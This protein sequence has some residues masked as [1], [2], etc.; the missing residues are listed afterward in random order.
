MRS[1]LV[2]A[3]ALM[4]SSISYSQG[5]HLTTKKCKNA[6][7]DRVRKDCIIR[8]IQ[9]FVD[10]NYDITAISS[11]AKP[12]SNRVYTRFKIDKTGKIVDIQTKSTAFPLEVEA[13]RVLESFPNLILSKS[14][15][16]ENAIIEEEVFTLPII[17]NVNK[18]EININLNKG[19]RLTGNQ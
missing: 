17:F 13:V 19:E 7:N 4:F 15:K 6:S 11:D 10:S 8:E 16:D 2:L 1:F 5:I 12:G 18:T 9:A 3:T 14:V